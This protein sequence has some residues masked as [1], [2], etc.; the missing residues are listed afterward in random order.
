MKNDRGA[1]AIMM[2]ILLVALVGFTAISV[3]VGA[4]WWD[5]KELQNGA[6]AAALALAQT[7]ASETG[8]DSEELEEHW[9]L[10]YAKAN[11]T[12]GDVTLAE[13]IQHTDMSVT[14]TVKSVREHWFASVLG[15][16]ESSVSATATATWGGVHGGWVA[17]FSA[18]TCFVDDFTAADW[19]VSN[20]KLILKDKLID[21]NP[22]GTTHM[23]PGGMDWLAVPKDAKDCQVYTEVDGWVLNDPGNDGTSNSSCA[24]L[25]SNLHGK[26]ILIPLFDDY[27]PKT[28]KEKV[29]D[30]VG[31]QLKQYHIKFYAHFTVD[32]YCLN[33]GK[34][35]AY[36][37]KCTGSERFLTGTFHKT[38]A[39]G[40][41]ELGG[42]VI[43]SSGVKLVIPG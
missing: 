39:L 15:R 26:D 7:C 22:G 3:D 42:P 10:H 19:P 5:R 34:G 4:L 31:K 2:A 20:L 38:V 35:W 37:E 41:V 29:G 30:V 11:K 14:V 33:G 32:T 27:E 9:A 1:V 36:G 8:C 24:S 12:D 40:D 43:G 23:M 16:S 13:G 18:S 25:L 28:G 21:C 6:D 17:P